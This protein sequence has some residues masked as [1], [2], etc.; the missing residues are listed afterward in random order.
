[1]EYGVQRY[2]QRGGAVR[3]AGSARRSGMAEPCRPRRRGHRAT[4]A[5]TSASA[6]GPSG[7]CSTRPPRGR[8]RCS[9]STSRTR[10]CP[11]GRPGSGKIGAIDVIIWQTGTARLL[12]H[13]LKGRKSGPAFITEQKA[14][15][16]LP[17]T[18]LGSCG[19]ARVSYQ[20]AA[21]LLS[22]ASG[23]ATLHQLRPFVLTHDAEEG[24]GTL[25]LMACS[26]HT[27]VQSLARYARVSAGVLARHWAEHDPARRR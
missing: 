7:G 15:V 5:R 24:T 6:S 2:C 23:G 25:K 21:A 3:E 22:G 20:Q 1:M 10:T 12:P 13:L 9:R 19:R 18:G 16:Q 4:P 26:G 17:A 27:S 11:T 8:P 14:R